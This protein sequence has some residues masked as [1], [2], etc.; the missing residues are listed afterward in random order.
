MKFFV[1]LLLFNFLFISNVNGNNRVIIYKEKRILN[2]V[3]PSEEIIKSFRISLGGV[4][5]GH[6]QC[7]GDQK[8][9]EGKYTLKYVNENSSYY[10]SIFINYPNEK[11]KKSAKKLNCPPGGMIMIHGIRNNLGWM[12]FF[13]TFFDWTKGCI[14]IKNSQIDELIS[15]LKL[16]AEIIINP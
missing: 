15:M 11:D 14:A 10:R 13:H 6:K 5:C 16:P 3:S 7:E 8:T 9:P 4:P 12:G 1:C 2:V